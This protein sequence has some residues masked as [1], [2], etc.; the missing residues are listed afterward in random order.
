MLEELK[1]KLVTKVEQIKY[2]FQKIIPQNG[3]EL[4]E[5]QRREKYILSKS[6][7]K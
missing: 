1:S 6:I 7:C 4:L 2:C 3:F 5:I